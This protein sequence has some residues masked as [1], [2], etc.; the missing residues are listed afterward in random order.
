MR[1]LLLGYN[2]ARWINPKTGSDV[3]VPQ[4]VD[5]FTRTP[6]NTKYFTVTELNPDCEWFRV[7][8]VTTLEGYEPAEYQNQR[9]GF[10][11]QIRYPFFIVAIFRADARQDGPNIPTSTRRSRAFWRWA[12]KKLGG[13]G[14]VFQIMFVR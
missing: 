9:F 1:R 3:F 8:H 5:K 4:M 14:E 11:L 10:S 2:L 6:E 7:G 13:T 12:G